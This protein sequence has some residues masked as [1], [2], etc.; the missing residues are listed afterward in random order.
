MDREA[1]IGKAHTAKRAFG[2]DDYGMQAKNR[3]SDLAMTPKPEPDYEACFTCPK[4]R[5]RGEKVELEAM[6]ETFQVTEAGVYGGYYCPQCH[7]VCTQKLFTFKS[8]ELEAHPY[9]DPLP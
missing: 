8:K 5:A 2:R 4:C 9:N 3:R 6:E 7:Y 1:P